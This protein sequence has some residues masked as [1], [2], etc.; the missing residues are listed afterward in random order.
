MAQGKEWTT[1]EKKESIEILG[2]V[3]KYLKKYE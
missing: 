2:S 3:I 1:E